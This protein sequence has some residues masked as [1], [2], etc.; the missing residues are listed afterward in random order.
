MRNRELRA[1]TIQNSKIKDWRILCGRFYAMSGQ[2]L[3]ADA[4]QLVIMGCNGSEMSPALA[5]V[6]RAL[7]PGGVILF[8]RNLQT[9]AQT[10]ELL[11]RCREAA[12]TQDPLFLCL[13]LEGGTVDRLREVIAHAPSAAEV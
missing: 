8:A 13:D 4:G 10:W 1:K 2:E 5:V 7:R 3:R 11:H 9:P 12:R 6:L